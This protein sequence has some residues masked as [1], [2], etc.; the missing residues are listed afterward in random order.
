MSGKII[1][2]KNQS[3]F[4]APRFRAVTVGG[5][6]LRFIEQTAMLLPLYRKGPMGPE[7]IPRGQDPLVDRVYEH[8]ICVHALLREVVALREALEEV[9]R[10]KPEAYMGIAERL[11]ARGTPTAQDADGETGSEVVD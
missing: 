5:T 11:E 7:P 8:D 9:C 10:S 4:E 3:T 1:L 6:P 2:P